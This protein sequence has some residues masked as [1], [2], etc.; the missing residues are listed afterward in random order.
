MFGICLGDSPLLTYFLLG[1]GGV[2][3]LLFQG[4]AVCGCIGFPTLASTNDA[5]E[6]KGQGWAGD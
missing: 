5:R 2:P 3:V 4:K 6:G 1:L